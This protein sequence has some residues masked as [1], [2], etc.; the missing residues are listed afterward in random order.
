MCFGLACKSAAILLVTAEERMKNLLRNEC[1][2]TKKQ[3][4]SHKCVN[5]ATLAGEGSQK[6]SIDN[7]LEMISR[8]HEAKEIRT[9]YRNDHFGDR[10]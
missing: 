2:V 7:A 3:S 1:C 5:N 4:R 9:R 10:L 6:P 8:I